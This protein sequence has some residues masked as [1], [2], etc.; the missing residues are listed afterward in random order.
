[1]NKDKAGGVLRKFAK[2]KHIL[3]TVSKQ[4]QEELR[5][6]NNGLSDV[7]SRIYHFSVVQLVTQPSIECEAE[8]DLVLIQSSSV[9]L[10]SYGNYS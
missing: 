2:E 9:F 3:K 6:G 4:Q 8:V 1:M 5:G 7:A 10:D